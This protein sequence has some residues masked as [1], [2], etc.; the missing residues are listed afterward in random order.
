[1]DADDL[2]L[3]AARRRAVIVFMAL[4]VSLL[5][6]LPALFLSIDWPGWGFAA[7]LIVGQILVIGLHSWWFR[8]TL[9]HP[10]TRPPRGYLV[11]AALVGSGVLCLGLLS[12]PLGS[13]WAL[14]AAILLGDCLAGRARHVIVPVVGVAVVVGVGLGL[15]LAPAPPGAGPNWVAASIVA[16]YLAALW[17]A[18]VNRRY[19][20]RSLTTLDRSRRNAADL[21]V[22]RERLRLA[23][24]LHDILGHALEVVAFK[25]E[26]A[27]KLLPP[28]AQRARVEIDE[29]AQVARSAMSEVRALA[30]DRRPTTL[31][32]ELAG[33]RATLVSAGIAL[34]VVGDP[35]A[36]A[37]DAQDVL[38]RVLRETMT[39]LLRHA[40]AGRCTVTVTHDSGTTRL[41]VVNDGAAG[42][43]GP[44]AGEGTGLSALERYLTERNGR[45]RTT[46]T[47]DGTFT[48]TAELPA[49]TP[50]R[51]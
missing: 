43:V 44:L 7:G 3:P 4:T 8:R 36:V 25:S 28:E 45:L 17:T 13:V 12:S 11:L 38:G 33:A 50:A 46:R 21:A 22:A 10:P 30:R 49:A 24:D 6:V 16:V 32:A 23:D 37:D 20:L 26:L 9:R 27:G 5:L 35:T 41:A 2:L 29:V 15:L 31:T 1:M 19:W 34:S 39:N 42:A 48:V 40:T 47:D 18:S 14:G 51:T